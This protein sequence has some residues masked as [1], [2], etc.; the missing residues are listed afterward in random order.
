MQAGEQHVGAQQP[1]SLGIA[2]EQLVRTSLTNAVTCMLQQMCRVT[3]WRM[4][5]YAD[6]SRCCLLNRSCKKAHLCSRGT[7]ST[8]NTSMLLN[9]WAKLPCRQ[10]DENSRH[11]S[12]ARMRG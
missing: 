12:P 3:A 5:L 7:A 8:A 10:M 2:S 6:V 11:H 1:W 9:R 4:L